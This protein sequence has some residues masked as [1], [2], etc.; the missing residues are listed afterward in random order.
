MP[1]DSNAPSA[2][3][4]LIFDIGTLQEG[5]LPECGR[6]VIFEADDERAKTLHK[7]LAGR[8]GVEI[9][10]AAIGTTDRDGTLHR[11]NLTRLNSLEPP[12]GL[13]DL[14]PGARLIEALPVRRTPLRTAISEI[15]PLKGALDIRIGAPGAEGDIFEGLKETGLLDQIETLTVN[16]PATTL[17]ANAMSMDDVAQWMKSE[18]FDLDATDTDDP[19]WPIYTFRANARL[20]ELQRNMA[21]S[22]VR[23]D[24]ATAE[25]A[26]L[27]TRLQSEKA[28]AAAL[29]HA[30]V[31]MT[32]ERDAARSETEQ[33]ARDLEKARSDLSFQMRLQG[34]HRIDVAD[35]REQLSDS[36]RQRQLIEDLLR[37]LTD[38][39]ERAAQEFR[40]L[41]LD[42][43]S[44]PEAAAVPNLSGAESDSLLA[45]GKRKKASKAQHG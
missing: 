19:D 8:R 32:R 13:F 12:Q 10:V 11:F 38:R 1:D 25:I 26:S 23:E 22:A 4:V 21:D 18:A 16:C 14:L 24:S 20:R 39:L 30:L 31:A 37:K 27:K 36:E 33:T 6:I 41:R 5:S 34:M 7:R 29:K 44:A 35:L 17:Y 40:D 45:K 28:E 42:E 15:L 2:A 9:V 3:T 43:E